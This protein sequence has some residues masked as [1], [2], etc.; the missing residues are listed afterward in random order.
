MTRRDRTGA[1]RR[2]FLKRAGLLAAAAGTGLA[3]AEIRPAAAEAE[4]AIAIE[5]FYGAHQGGILTPAQCHTY[6]AAFD[7]D[8]KKRAE[9]IA[10]LLVWTDAAEMMSRGEMTTQPGNDGDA[11]VDIAETFGLSPS[12]LTVTFGFGPGVFVKDGKNR[13]DLA[14]SRP[15]ALID[16]PRF[17]G[18]Q[19]IADRTGGDI[20][21]QACADDPQVAF[22]AIR[23]LSQLGTGM[24]HV[25]WGQTGFLPHSP[26]GETPR[27]L[28]GFK[29]GT[30]NPSPQDKTAI[31]QFVF[32]GDD[33]PAWMRGGSYVVARRILIA[34]E[35]WDRMRTNFQEQT[36]GRHK[37]TGAPL[38]KK[39][40]SD[41]LDFE[42][43]GKDGNP[44]TPINAHVRLAAAQSNGGARVL[45]RPYSYNDGVSY[46]AERWPPWRQG[47][48]YDAGLFFICYQ[49]DPREGFVKIYERMSRLDLLNQFTTHTGGGLFACPPGAAPGEYIGQKLFDA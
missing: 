5:P 15:P 16:M 6:F 23:R 48:E 35:H 47:I 49:R 28:M 25:R 42:T 20:S 46:T 26:D 12:R 27:N 9:V 43:T 14:A 34:L 45:R 36:F 24:A 8:A 2:G 4:S 40:E 32:A 22:H 38:G 1:S 29:D 13:Y 21:V 44:L 33:G 41:A 10:L 37:L 7:L 19:L 18:D 30:G 3:Q 39:N 17:I 11:S 31:E